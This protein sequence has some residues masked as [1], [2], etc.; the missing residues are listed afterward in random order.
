VLLNTARTQIQDTVSEARDAL[1]NLRQ[2]QA[3]SNFLRDTLRSI[4]THAATTFGVRVEV[5][6]PD[7]HCKLPASSA[8]E[9][10]MIVREA[11]INAGTHGSPRSI[12]IS[13][14]SASERLSVEVADDGVGFDAAATP[15]SGTDHFGLRGMRERAA[16]IG[17][18]LE[19]DS[20]PGAGTVVRIS[21]PS[22][23]RG[24]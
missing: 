10:M 22:S 6:C 7:K 8:H 20:K 23:E 17:A 5:H 13:A 11:V 15:L 4:G 21:L 24:S 14:K 19:I 2:S 9:L 16:A 18:K 12:T 3:D 1:W